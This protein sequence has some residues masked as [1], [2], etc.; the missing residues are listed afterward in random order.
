MTLQNG[1]KKA[2]T[3]V[4]LMVVVAMIA[5]IIAAMVT[6]IAGAKH[7]TKVQKATSEVKII[8]Q[9]ILAYENYNVGGKFELPTI[10]DQNADRSTL[11]F[12]LGEG[13]QARSGKIPALLI[14]ALNNG[15]A[16]LD[17]WGTPYKIK[18]SKGA[19][20]IKINSANATMRT[21]FVVPNYYHLTEGER[22]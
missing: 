19:G 16:I 2:F 4:E 3:L 13:D 7:R 14:A 6:S 5:M 8:S 15:Q 20:K 18:I 22:K 10:N 9:A 1:N 21:G 11:S 17:P 12:L